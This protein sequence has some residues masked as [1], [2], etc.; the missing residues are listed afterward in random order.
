LAGIDEL[1]E[2]ERDDPWL[3]LYVEGFAQ[4]CEHL[5]LGRESWHQAEDEGW[6]TWCREHQTELAEAFLHRAESG[7][8]VSEFF[9]SWF[10]FRGKKQTGYFLGHECILQLER[11]WPLHEI[12]RLLDD[13]VRR[14][15]KRY[16]QMAIAGREH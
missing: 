16:L 10:E 1:E 7:Q 5:I 6:L 12:A 2:F 13:E 4:R 11:K 14:Q 9:G 8:S 3:Q 15:M